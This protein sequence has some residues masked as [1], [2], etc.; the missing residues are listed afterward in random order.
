MSSLTLSAARKRFDGIRRLWSAVQERRQTFSRDMQ[1][2]YGAYDPP[3]AWMTRTEIKRLDS[4]LTADSKRTD[5]MCALLDD[6]SPRD[7]RSGV[8]SHWLMSDLTFEDATTRGALSV[9]PPCAYGMRPA[10]MEGFR[11]KVHGPEVDPRTFTIDA[12]TD[13]ITAELGTSGYLQ[14]L[15]LDGRACVDIAAAI[16]A[17]HPCADSDC[18]ICRATEDGYPFHAARILN[19]AT[20]TP[21]LDAVVRLYTSAGMDFGAAA[22]LD[23]ADWLK[24]ETWTKHAFKCGACNGVTFGDES[25]TPDQCASCGADE[26]APVAL[27]GYDVDAFVDGYCECALWSDCHPYDPRDRIAELRSEIESARR[28]GRD[29]QRQLSELDDLGELLDD[30]TGELLNDESGGCEN[31]TVRNESRERIAAECRDFI[32]ANRADLDAYGENRA[33]DPSQG[34]V[35]SYAGHDFYL[36][37]VGHGT[38]FW[39]RGLGDLGDRLAAACKPFEDV[40]GG[41]SLIDCGDGTA[42]LLS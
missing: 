13:G 14:T 37:R 42:E 33:Y 7:W 39:D 24:T 32:A 34:S 4:I 38:G 27:D 3:R 18:D 1:S 8:P 22:D 15:A 26:I 35:E 12:P 10:D 40:S 31:L 28:L 17:E 36:T 41:L 9:V 11:C 16:G 30:E 25:W 20:E 2:R 6:I 19:G 5:Q 23:C 21:L 29:P